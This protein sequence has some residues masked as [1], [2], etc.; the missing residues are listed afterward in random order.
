MQYF[1]P[2]ISDNYIHFTGTA[3]QFI[4]T[5]IDLV[6]EQVWLNRKRVILNEDY[7]KVSNVGLMKSPTFITGFNNTIYNN[8]N[9]FFNT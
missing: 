4:N 3:N 8:S 7:L 2:R 9:N 6:E 5:N 1:L